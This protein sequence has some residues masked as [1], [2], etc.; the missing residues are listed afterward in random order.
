[1]DLRKP[2]DG[3]SLKDY[4]DGS[5]TQWFGENVELYSRWGLQGH[6]GIDLVAPHGTPLYAVEDATVIDVNYNPN[7]FG[8]HI[9]ILSKDAHNGHHREWSYAHCA[10]VEKVV[11]EE[12]KAGERIATMGNTGFV[13]SGSN[14]WWKYNPYAGTHLHLGLRIAIMSETGWRYNDKA[15]L[16]EIKNYQNGMKGAIDWRPYYVGNDEV[17]KQQMLTIISLLQTIIRLLTK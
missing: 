9:R 16:M 11:G 10:T 15:P 2:F 1:M 7:G 13:V 14:P 5:V 4:P 3:F 6:N 17:K 8:K 12:V